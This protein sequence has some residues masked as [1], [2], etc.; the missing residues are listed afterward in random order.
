MNKMTTA[1]WCPLVI[2]FFSA[3]AASKVSQI[4][5]SGRCQ[6]TSRLMLRLVRADRDLEGGSIVKTVTMATNLRPLPA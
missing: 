4:L 5:P 1:F 6:E 3:A 2:C